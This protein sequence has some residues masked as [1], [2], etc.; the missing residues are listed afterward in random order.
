MKG[1]EEQKLDGIIRVFSNQ[2]TPNRTSQYFVADFW[3]Y[4]QL[5]PK[6]GVSILIYTSVE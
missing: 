2:G 5:Q 4:S 6:K 3:V 1:V